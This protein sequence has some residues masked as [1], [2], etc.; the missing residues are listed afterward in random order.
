MNVNPAAAAIKYAIELGG[1]DGIDFLCLW[2][3]GGFPEIRRE[4]PDAPK[5]IFI[6]ADPT[7]G[8]GSTDPFGDV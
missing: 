5:E 4:Y 6:G 2:Y 3:E 8:W 1:R 7:Y